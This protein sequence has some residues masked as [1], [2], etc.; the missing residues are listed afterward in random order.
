[1]TYAEEQYKANASSALEKV[2]EED[3]VVET[4]ENQKK[5]DKG[6]KQR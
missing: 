4:S 2:K 1:M 6:N 5:K 3:N